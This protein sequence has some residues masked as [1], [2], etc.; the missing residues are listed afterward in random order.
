MQSNND[1]KVEFS[2][3]R[4]FVPKDNYN[5]LNKMQLSNYQQYFVNIK[6]L[7]M[8]AYKNKEDNFAIN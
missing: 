7:W 1:Y 5:K 8:I 6:K 2:I 4:Y 3:L